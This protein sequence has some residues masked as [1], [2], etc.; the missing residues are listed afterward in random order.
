MKLDAWVAV[1]IGFTLHASAYLGEIWRGAIEA[2][3]RGQTEAAKALE[4]QLRLA[5]EGRDPAAGAAHLAAGDD[6]LPRAA[7]QGHLARRHRRLHRAHPRRATSSRTRSSSRCSSSASSG[8]LY[9]VMCWPLSLYGARL[10]RQFAAAA[11]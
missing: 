11:R 7:H 4:P 10:E 5:H 2:V 8:A 1:A 3:P 6:R 9:F